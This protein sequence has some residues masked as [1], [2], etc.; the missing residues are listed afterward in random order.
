MLLDALSVTT[1]AGTARGAFP[2]ATIGATGALR[3]DGVSVARTGAAIVPGDTCAPLLL[4]VITSWLL[5][6]AAE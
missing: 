5:A 2:A 4:P 3:T 6:L 1:A